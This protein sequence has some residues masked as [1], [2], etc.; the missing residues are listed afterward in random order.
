MPAPKVVGVAQSVDQGPDPLEVIAA[1]LDAVIESAPFGIGLFDLQIRHVR[2]NPVLEEMNGLPASELLGRRPAELHPSVGG[3]AEL[4]YREVMHSGRPR[5]DVLLTGEIGSRPGDIRHWN[6]SFFPVRQAHEVIGLCVVVADVTAEH[7]LT[8]ALAA[9]EE[10]HRRLAEDL[11][12]SLLPHDLPRLA[13]M[14]LGSVY[15]PSG[16]VASV[17]GDF[18]DL[19]ELDDASCLLVI[20][21]VEG[22]GPVAASL[23]AAVRYAIR[24]T[25][26]R[27][28]DPAELLRIANEVLLREGAPNG[29]CTVACVL[30]TRVGE[31]IELRAA[32]AG[33]PLPLILRSG[34]DAVE[35]V[36][37]PG[38]LLGILPDVHLPVSSATLSAGDVLVLYTDGVTE[39]R[40]RTSGGTLE[41]FGE[42]RLRSVLAASTS[43][44]AAEIARTVE[45]AVA[46]FESGHP[47]DDLAVLV[48]KV[49]A[50][51]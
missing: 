22:T 6:A 25:A 24:A 20:G 31:R 5:R 45:T 10:S 39:A 44:S 32:S 12:R 41:M 3:E 33:H 37:A 30:A 11:Q 46:T 15:R 42:E 13:G 17:G 49:A 29:T 2:V 18:Y 7:R 51:E 47:A 26:V 50:G 19:V 28:T 9:S 8:V 1:Q 40:Y 34:S 35:E 48:L 16:V 36:G 38:P 27:N 43:A 21:D 4:L 14:E 23:T